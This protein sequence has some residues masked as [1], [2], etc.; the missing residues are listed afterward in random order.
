MD[1][2]DQL[3]QQFLREHT[4]INSV[5]LATEEIGDAVP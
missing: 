1:R 3:F 2:L 4:Y 5:T